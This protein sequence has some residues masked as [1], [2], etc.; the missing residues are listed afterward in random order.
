MKKL[1][2]YIFVLFSFQGF[3]QKEDSVQIIYETR[4]LRIRNVIIDTVFYEKSFVVT[5]QDTIRT[6]KIYLRD[7]GRIKRGGILNKHYNHWLFTPDNLYLYS[8]K[9]SR[10]N[11]K[12]AK[13]NP[14][15]F[16]RKMDKK[17]EKGKLLFYKIPYTYEINYFKNTAFKTI[18]K[19]VCLINIETGDT[20]FNDKLGKDE[21][22]RM[23][24]PDVIKYLF[25]T[26]TDTIEGIL[27]SNY[28]RREFDYVRDLFKY[29]TVL[30]QVVTSI[31]N[32][33]FKEMEFEGVFF[34]S[35]L[36]G[37]KKY[38]LVINSENIMAKKLVFLDNYGNRFVCSYK[39]GKDSIFI[40][41]PPISGF[42][43]GKLIRRRGNKGKLNLQKEK[44]QFRLN[45]KRYVF[46]HKSTNYN[47]LLD[48]MY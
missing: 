47:A 43:N 18:Q 35:K 10:R 39:I 27:D 7:F 41:N 32:N 12:R 19:W 23:G 15:K 26:K 44:I 37:N 21:I 46:S 42:S 33:R 34:C 38:Q 11:R 36:V 45:Q 16:F 9:I 2:I 29:E 6:K 20:T 13:K 14:E 28:K 3:G 40:E 8:K 31:V 4:S 25:T 24:A 48:K 30:N 1:S 17:V 5:E 22:E